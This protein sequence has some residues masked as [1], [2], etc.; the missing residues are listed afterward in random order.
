LV[1]AIRHGPWD[2]PG[3]ASLVW[4]DG[5]GRRVAERPLDLP[6]GARPTSLLAAGDRT[7]HAGTFVPPDEESSGPNGWVGLVDDGTRQWLWEHRRGAGG[8][9]ADLA[10]LPDGDVVAVGRVEDAARARDAWAARMTT[11]G[12]VR[13]ERPVP[14]PTA[15]G[16]DSGSASGD[17]DD[18]FR[19]VLAHPEGVVVGG[20][21][22][23]PGDRPL[24]ARL[25]VLA[26]DG[27]VVWDRSYVQPADAYYFTDLARAGDGGYYAVGATQHYAMGNNHGVAVAVDADGTVRWRR[28]FD[29]ASGHGDVVPYAVVDRD[30]PVLAG[31][32]DLGET[33]GAA[34][35]GSLA[36]DGAVRWLGPHAA[37]ATSAVVAATATD[38]RATVAGAV[39]DDPAAPTDAWLA[40]W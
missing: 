6:A 23:P 39:A 30:G 17:R 22:D 21:V 31:R 18:D 36:P 37:A 2:A 3:S 16:D 13:W 5:D 1:L 27:T 10:A 4:T 25:A 14:A 8:G 24:R 40:G 33:A 20:S 32:T 11:A 26:P 19:C 9:V 28:L 38:D 7:Y 12:E 29:A 34:W 35:L 15:D